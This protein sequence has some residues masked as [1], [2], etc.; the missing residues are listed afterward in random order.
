M[1]NLLSNAV[2]STREGG[3]VYVS[4][5]RKNGALVFTIK[6]TGIG[7]AAD[8]IS[9]AMASFGQVESKVSRKYQGTG[10]G[11]PLAKHLVELHG[12]TLTIES[13]VNVGTIVTVILPGQRIVAQ[14]SGV[15]LA[16]V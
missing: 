9:K 8:D 16:I 12:G 5:I 14:T 1:L 15:A 6:D 4:S 2:K 3:R 11:L 13:E 7:I 10:R